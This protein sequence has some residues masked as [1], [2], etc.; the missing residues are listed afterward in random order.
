MISAVLTASLYKAMLED[1]RK[2]KTQK[3]LRNS[4]KAGTGAKRRLR[5]EDPVAGTSGVKKPKKVAPKSNPS[6]SDASSDDDDW[7]CLVCVWRTIRK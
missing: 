1:K 2:G 7:P 3:L 5:V 6:A 4:K